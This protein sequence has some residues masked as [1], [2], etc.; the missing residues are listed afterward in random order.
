MNFL[1]Q[2]VSTLNLQYN[3]NGQLFSQ[4]F[5]TISA[6]QLALQ[7]FE[8]CL[9]QGLHIMSAMYQGVG[10]QPEASYTFHQDTD[11]SGV[12]SKVTEIDSINRISRDSYWQQ[13]G[14]THILINAIHCLHRPCSAPSWIDRV[15][16]KPSVKADLTIC[17]HVFG[18][19]RQCKSVGLI[20]SNKLDFSSCVILDRFCKPIHISFLYND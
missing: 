16:Q 10:G 19:F 8:Q 14:T 5:I 15:G 7:D 2:I 1:C 17:I 12:S 20:Y 13:S 4:C 3:Q 18:V 6:S 9:S 11:S